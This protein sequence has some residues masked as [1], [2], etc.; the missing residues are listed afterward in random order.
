MLHFGGHGQDLLLSFL[1]CDNKY[2]SNLKCIVVFMIN[3]YYSKND[4]K[5]F[6]KSFVYSNRSR[7]KL[8]IWQINTQQNNT[9]H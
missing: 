4:R 9:Q 3:G 2:K 1:K 5:K 6:V 8:I 7:A